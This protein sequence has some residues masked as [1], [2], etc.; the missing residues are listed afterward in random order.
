MAAIHRLTLY[1][2]DPM[3][4]YGDSI[5]EAEED[6]DNLIGEDFIIRTSDAETKLFEWDDE[7]P[8][9]KLNAGVSEFEEF[10]NKI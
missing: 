8:V 7:L 9:N 1:I 3:D 2:V 6:I 10:F 5:T 4:E